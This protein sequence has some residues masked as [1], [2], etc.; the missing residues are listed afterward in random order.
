MSLTD[1]LSLFGQFMLLSLLSIGGYATVLPDA[2]RHLVEQRGLLS[3]TEFAQA[4]ALGQVNPGPNI[5]IMGMLGWAAA[6]WSGLLACLLGILLPSTLLVWR[7]SLWVRRHR[8]HPAL[9]AFQAG[10]LPL[11]LGLTFASALLLAQPFVRNGVLAWLLLATVAA[12]MAW[13]PRLPPLAW[14]VL[15]GCAGALGWV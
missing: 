2:H 10:S 1:G 6:G 3:D 9:C 4:V 8:D 5:L 14:L 13:K 15:G 11:V 7:V 12:G